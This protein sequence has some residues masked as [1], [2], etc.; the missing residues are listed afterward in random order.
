MAYNA[1]DRLNLFTESRGSMPRRTVAS[2]LQQVARDKKLRSRF[3]QFAAL[4]GFDLA[5]MTEEDVEM[6][7]PWSGVT[8]TRGVSQ[9]VSPHPEGWFHTHAAERRS[10][11]DRR[12][13]ELLVPYERRDSVGRRGRCPPGD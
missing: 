7:G 2:F 6:A 13:E 8:G 11:N 10:G 1:C 12:R 3:A 9:A 4:H 5:D